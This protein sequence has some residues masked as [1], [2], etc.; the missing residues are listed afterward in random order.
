MLNSGAVS[1]MIQLSESSRRIE[2]HGEAEPEQPGPRLLRCWKP[3]CQDRDEHD[4]VDT[5]HDLEHREGGKADPGLGITDPVHR[6]SGLK[7]LGRR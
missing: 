3:V 4:V 5:Q 2:L 1:P 6:K 7:G